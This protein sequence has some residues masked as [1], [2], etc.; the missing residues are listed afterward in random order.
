MWT[1]KCI[2]FFSFFCLTE[3]SKMTQRL[4]LL[5]LSEFNPWTRHRG[6]QQNRTT[7]AWH[8][9][10]STYT[11]R[12]VCSCSGVHVC[13][14]WIN[15][16]RIIPLYWSK[17]SFF[18]FFFIYLNFFSKFPLPPLFLFPSMSL[19]RPSHPNP[20]NPKRGPCTPPWLKSQALPQNSL[21][22]P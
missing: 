8:S 18:L 5:S 20:S 9:I 22:F 3:I 15:V 12:H 4:L 7:P 13:T 17:Y 1:L 21:L 10:T 2:L 6:A 19:H 11:P 16:K 14:T